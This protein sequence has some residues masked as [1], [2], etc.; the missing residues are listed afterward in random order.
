MGGVVGWS[1]TEF[2]PKFW[3]GL[4]EAQRLLKFYL[5]IDLQL[6]RLSA[7]LF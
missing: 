5:A 7:F 1:S 6:P 4:E 3:A 2:D